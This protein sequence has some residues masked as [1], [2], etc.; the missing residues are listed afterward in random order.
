MK[1]QLRCE[2][3]ATG[4]K[5]VAR[6]E[7]RVV[8][9]EGAAPNETV[10]AEVV[11]DKGRFLEA[12]VL[13]IIEPSADRV[14]PRCRHFGDCGGCS[15]QYLSYPA[16]LSA[17]KSM[18]EDAFRRLG[19][20]GSWPAIELVSGEPWGFRNRAQFQPPERDGAWGFFAAGSRRA[21]ALQECPVL[22]DELQGAWDELASRRSD[23]WADRRQRTVFAWGAQGRR[24]FRGPGDP[25][26]EP[27]EAVVGSRALKFAVDGFFQSNLALVP[28]MVELATGGAQGTEAWDLYAGVGL[29]ASHLEDRF[30][31]VHAV[32]SDPL[33]AKWA[34]ANL[35][36]AIY[37]DLPVEQWLLSRLESGRIGPDLAV[38]DPPRQGLTGIALE[39]LVACKPKAL[40]YV[41]CGHDT[42]AR[43]LKALVGAG[44]ALDKVFLLDLYP[45]T[46]H[47]EVVVHLSAPA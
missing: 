19:K 13:E 11:V 32:E 17:K 18:L 40:R 16:Q 27:A 37:H 31:T 21:V 39:R 6:H 24:W 30:G 34:P 25:P 23:P 44:Y 9:V 1:L 42:L 20:L 4:G 7:G 29:F 47:L 5:A 26:G 33:A 38:V 14:Q 10:L 12:R 3:L 2:S 15:W 45:H 41:S 22:A 8:F 35:A 43:D 46:P 28:R 36:K